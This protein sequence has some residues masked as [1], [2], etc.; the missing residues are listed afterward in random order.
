MTAITANQLGRD[1]FRLPT[2]LFIPALILAAAALSA[3]FSD[4]IPVG[5]HE[6]LPY[7]PYGLA[8][9][10]AVLGWRFNRSRLV[11]SV[12]AVAVGHWL[13][14]G[15]A[16]NFTA[17]GAGEAGFVAYATVYPALLVTLALLPERGL[18]TRHGIV[19]TLLIGLLALVLT[20][21]A[22][23]PLWL[24]PDIAETLRGGFIA[25]L[26]PRLAPAEW[27]GWIELPHPA[28]AIFIL[29]A[30]F[31]VVRL[32][33]L[34]R[35]PLESGAMG[36]LVAVAA[37]LHFA[38]DPIATTLFSSSAALILVVAV[39][40]DT[41]RLAFLDELTG[42]PGRRALTDETLKLGQ[43]YAIAMLDVDH[44]KKF[45]DK[46]GHDVG[47][48]V[49]RMV[50]SRM[51][52][53]NGGGKPFR[54]GG[55]E[56][57]VLFPGKTKEEALPHLEALRESIADSGFVIRGKDRPRKKPD[58]PKKQKNKPNKVSVTIS[59]GVAERNDDDRDP[60]A[61]LRQADQALYKAKKDG[62][63]RVSAAA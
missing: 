30:A 26:S 46:Y 24:A 40:Q 56:F 19:R 6:L 3:R 62:R 49:L 59:I 4:R 58:P 55:E 7:L 57:T 31:F 12:A 37:A 43:S 15:P 42:L 11:F 21:I 17:G 28:T 61:V 45:N 8:A 54:Y 29:A 14:L 50:A 48:Q 13:L 33:M 53:V 44:F 38:G 2:A 35:P 16:N 52:R 20:A 41:Y 51:E 39:V 36:A 25:I 47:D 10:A 32:V 27:A 5:I 18:L 1:A 63:N 22:V 60:D 9:G 23:A 34:G